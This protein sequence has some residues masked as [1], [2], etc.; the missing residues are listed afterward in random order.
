ML[1]RDL[2]LHVQVIDLMKP[3]RQEI[4]FFNALQQATKERYQINGWNVML[5]PH[6][7]DPFAYVN[8]NIANDQDR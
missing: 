4:G 8:Y 1:T 5:I 6:P 3:G 2:D 7:R